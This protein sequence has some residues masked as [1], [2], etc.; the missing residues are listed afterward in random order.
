VT[1]TNIAVVTGRFTGG[2]SITPE[3]RVTHGFELHC[4]ASDV[5]NNLEINNGGD[6]F[7]LVTLTT[8]TCYIDGNGVAYIEGTGTGTFN[9]VSAYKISFT[10][11]DAGEPGT[12]DFASYVITD[13]SGNPVSSVTASGYLQSGNQQFH[14]KK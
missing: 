6:N 5:P 9:G 7:H 4:D 3:A 11:T 12:K 1:F 14:K 8:G 10:L 13:S 2:G